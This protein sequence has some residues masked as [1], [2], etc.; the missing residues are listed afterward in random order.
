MSSVNWHAL[1]M[2]RRRERV[3][4]NFAAMCDFFKAIFS[5]QLTVGELSLNNATCLCVILGTTSLKSH[6]NKC[7]T[8]SRS[9]FV[10]D[11]H[12]LVNETKLLVMSCC[13]CR[14]N[15]IGGNPASCP[16]TTPPTPWLD[17]STILILLDHPATRS[18]H[19][20]GHM[21]VSYC[22]VLISWIASRI[23]PF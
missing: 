8:I 12:W 15:I 20:V 4:R 16:R 5:T 11:P 22:I 14:W 21:A 17:A 7:P 1:L 2:L 18:L 19:N 23:A 10:I 9:K 13:H 6:K 3:Q